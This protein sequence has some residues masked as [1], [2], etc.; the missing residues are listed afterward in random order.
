MQLHHLL[1]HQ[2]PEAIIMS[3]FL[4]FAIERQ[5]RQQP[6]HI[7]T[8]GSCCY[9]Q[10]PTS[11]YAAYSGVIDLAQHDVQRCE[12]A[13]NFLDTGNFPNA[14][15]T[16]FAARVQGIQNIPRAELTALKLAASLPY[17]IIHSDSQYAI[18]RARQTCCA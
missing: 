9:P 10:H 4:D 3:T 5:H 17:G 16:C 15:T 11:R 2:Q 18:G 1:H 14:L 7:Y 12:L 6:F 13:Q 8:D